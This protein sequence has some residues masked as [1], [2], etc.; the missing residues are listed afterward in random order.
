MFSVNNV[1]GTKPYLI[2]STF[3]ENSDLEASRNTQ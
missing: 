1:V 2:F 3:F